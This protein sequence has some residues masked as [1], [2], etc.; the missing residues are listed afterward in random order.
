[1][2]QQLNFQANND[3]KLAQ[4][5]SFKVS[6]EEFGIDIL[7]VQEIIRMLPIAIVPSAPNFVKGVI[8]LRGEVI[9]IIDMRKRFKLPSIPYNNETRIIVVHTHDFTVG[10]IVDAVCEVIRINESAIEPAP[11]VLTSTNDGSN[12]IRG[13]SKLD[14]GLLILLDLNNLISLEILEELMNSAKISSRCQECPEAQKA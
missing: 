3:N 11:P 13:V 10:F 1:M 14:K 9:P 8:D 7:Q 4:L 2:S 12:Y 5:V 6:E